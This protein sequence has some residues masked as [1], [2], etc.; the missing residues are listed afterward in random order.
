MIGIGNN[1]LMRK[2]SGYSRP[3]FI[4]SAS[5]IV[6][7]VFTITLTKPTSEPIEVGDLLIIL[8]GNDSTSSSPCWD[9]TTNKPSGFTLIQAYSQ[10]GSGFGAFWKIADGTETS[11]IDVTSIN[12]GKTFGSYIHIK[13]ANK[14]TPVPVA[15]VR[16]MYYNASVCYFYGYDGNAD[17]LS[18]LV[19]CFDG[20]D[21]TVA[22]QDYIN[23]NTIFVLQSGAGDGDVIGYAQW[24]ENTGIAPLEQTVTYSVVDNT[25]GVQFRIQK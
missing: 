24:G 19:G 20:G 6:G 23:W 8:V 22:F 10:G 18:M 21:T 25:N 11:T 1:M 2:P 17:D 7:T 12:S 14:T 9:N 3:T 15:G 16:R 5:S 4:Q 13:G